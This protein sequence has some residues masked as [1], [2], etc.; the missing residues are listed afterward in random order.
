MLEELVDHLPS[1]GP[2]FCDDNKTVF[3]MIPKAAAGE[4]VEFTIKS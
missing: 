4:S 2:I 1:A 3:V